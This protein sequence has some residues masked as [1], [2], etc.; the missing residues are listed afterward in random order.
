MHTYIPWEN[1][2]VEKRSSGCTYVHTHAYIY[3]YIHSYI[4]IYI[5]THIHTDTLLVLTYTPTSSHTHICL[6]RCRY[7]A[8]GIAINH[9]FCVSRSRSLSAHLH[10]RQ[11]SPHM[12]QKPDPQSIHLVVLRIMLSRS[13]VAPPYMKA[14]TSSLVSSMIM[15]CPNC[16]LL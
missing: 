7:R 14:V 10:V 16:V 2:L 9:W 8:L 5:Y 12:G 4:H 3:T 11:L 13:L 1:Q 6:V 15:M